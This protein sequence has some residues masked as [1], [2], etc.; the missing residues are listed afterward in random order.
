MAE[1]RSGAA[2]TLACSQSRLR[3]VSHS[4][5]CFRHSPSVSMGLHDSS[6]NTATLFRCPCL[7]K[8]AAPGDRLPRE[9]DLRRGRAGLPRR[10]RP[11][12]PD[13]LR[14]VQARRGG[15]AERR[16]KAGVQIER[17]VWHAPSREHAEKTPPSEG[18]ASCLAL[19]SRLG[20]LL[21]D[22]R[23]VHH[24]PA[25]S[26][27][28]STCEFLL[29]ARR[30]DDARRHLVPSGPRTRGHPPREVGAGVS[31]FQLRIDVPLSTRRLLASIKPS[32]MM[33]R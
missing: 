7:V 24:V 18:R 19:R 21:R 33:D 17:Y 2:S 10:A 1:R 15:A 30:R 32:A 9:R 5:N 29:R 4:F 14:V 23:P 28:E 22:E 6:P 12:G 25:A 27:L 3:L 16:G 13:A 11:G 31:P 8:G 26:Q 20:A